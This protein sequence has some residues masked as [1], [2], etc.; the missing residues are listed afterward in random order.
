MADFNLNI[1]DPDA[2]N[3]GFDLL[4]A[5]DYVVTLDRT[6]K[7]QTKNGKQ[8]LEFAFSVIDGQYKNRKLWERFFIYEPE[9]P[10]SLVYAKRM[11]AQMLRALGKDSMTDTSEL[12][13]RN[14][15]IHVKVDKN[16]EYGDRNVIQSYKPVPPVSV[17]NIDTSAAPW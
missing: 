11:I 9:K 16:A 14:F 10:G 12:E 7:K 5:G 2:Q 6:E 4:P 1:N 15:L 3:A 13:G 17:G 8:Y